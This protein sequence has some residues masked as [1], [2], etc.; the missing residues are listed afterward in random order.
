MDGIMGG[1]PCAS[2]SRARFLGGM[3]P[4]PLRFRGLWTWGRED[5]TNAEARRVTEANVLLINFVALAE[6]VSKR[7]GLGLLEHPEDPEEEPMPSIWATDLIQ[8]F[9]ARCQYSRAHPH[10]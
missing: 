7:G 1:P 8:Q 10:Q 5:L 2:W 9:E 6:I 3:G 4:R